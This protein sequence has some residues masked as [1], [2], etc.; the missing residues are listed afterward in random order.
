MLT[1]PTSI[2]TFTTLTNIQS[3][4]LCFLSLR[5]VGSISKCPPCVSGVFVTQ[6]MTKTSDSLGQRDRG[7][8][9]CKLCN[10]TSKQ[11]SNMK[12][13]VILKHTKKEHLPCPGCNKVLNNKQHFND[14]LADSHH[15]LYDDQKYSLTNCKFEFCI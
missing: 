13:H 12:R 5:K 7:H 11:I 9:V 8:W 6:Y 3:Q 2:P 15:G 1:W 4:T 14:H 10:Y